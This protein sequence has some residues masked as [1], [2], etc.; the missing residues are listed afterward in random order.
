MQVTGRPIGWRTLPSR[1]GGGPFGRCLLAIALATAPL[2]SAAAAD[3]PVPLV[4][5]RILTLEEAAA[6]GRGEQPSVAAFEREAAASE[7]AAVAAR[8]L[9]DPQISAGVQNYPVTGDVAFNPTR[10]DMTM[11][12]IGVMREQ[13]RRSRREA[14]AARLRAEA[15]VSRTEG[16]VQDRQIQRAVM[17]AWINAVEAAAKQRLLARVINDLEAGRRIMEAGIPT[18]ASTPALALQAQA[19]VSLAEAELAGARGAEARARAELARWIGPAAHRPLPESIPGIALPSG[20]DTRG[21]VDEHPRVRLAEAQEQ[22]ARHQ[23]DAART[24]RRPNLTWSVMYGWRPEYGDMVSAQ[25]TIPIQINRGRLQ[26]R[27]IAEAEAR[28]DSARLRAEDARRELG[29]EYEAALAD[30]RSAEAQLSILRDQAIPSLEASFEA[31]EA[32]YAGGQGNLELPLN[33]VRRYVEAHIQSAEQQ[34]RRARAAAEI[35][36]LTGETGQ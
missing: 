6:L 10:D 22:A 28:A 26:N 27:R 15:V 3:E 18:G 25:V 33:I 11:Y 7:E 14:E 21:F 4:P 35:I 23:V 12:T 8:T 19:E 16:S 32:R 30:Y 17:I 5:G 29:G 20:V 1:A 9:P 2:G 36:Y 13:V 34:G 31:A 24:E